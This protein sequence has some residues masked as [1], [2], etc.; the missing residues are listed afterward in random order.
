MFCSLTGHSQAASN[1]A[2]ASSPLVLVGV[3]PVSGSLDMI[4]NASRALGVERDPG[5]DLHL[6]HAGCGAVRAKVGN[7]TRLYRH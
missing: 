4:R 6:L 2:A 5:V 1:P 3:E 7:R